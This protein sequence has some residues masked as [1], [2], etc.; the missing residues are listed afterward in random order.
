MKKILTTLVVATIFVAA[1]KKDKTPPAVP[2][3]TTAAL[4]NITTTSATA[5]GTITS[6]GGSVITASGVVLSRSKPTPTLT[7]TVV[8]N[9]VTT[10]SF[11]ANITGLEFNRTY[12]IRAYATNAIGTSYGD[13]VT[14]NTTNDTT[15]VRFT[16]NGQEVVYGIITSSLTGKNGWIKI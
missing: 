13:V 1:C 16:Y 8:T 10:G 2:T 12:Y 4:T 15:K 6:D 14:L 9:T 3:V 5:G 11:T 7:D